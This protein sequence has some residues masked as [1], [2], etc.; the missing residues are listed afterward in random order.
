MD[1]PGV[2]VRPIEQITGTGEFCEVF[3][4]AAEASPEHVV[5]GVNQGWR[6]AMGTLGFERGAST[7]GQQL[8]FRNE[9]AQI[10]EIAR[11][12]GVLEDPVLRDRPV[13]ARMGLE[14]LRLN[15]LR[16][17]TKMEGGALSRE[18]LV[19]KITW[20]T[21]HRALGR[22]AMEVLGA[23]SEWAQGLPYERTMLQRLFLFTRSDT[24]YAGSNQIQ[25][26]I[27]ACLL[28]TSDAADEL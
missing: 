17:L 18:A 8:S 28:Y 11:K 20:A 12:N 6:A 9:L 19:R 25:R 1:Q 16:M 4:D 13:R 5:G 24:I 2:K 15:A 7:L 27:I 14:T 23:Q 21:W 22:L 3:F 10:T 26:N